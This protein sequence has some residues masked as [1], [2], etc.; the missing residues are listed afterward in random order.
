MFIG[1]QHEITILKDLFQKKTA[2]LVTVTGK[3]R[4]GKST[5][6]QYF[7]G[8][9]MDHF[10]EFQGIAPRD[11]IENKNQ[12]QHFSEQLALQFNL[13]TLELKNWNEAFSL[14]SNQV[15][16]KSCLILLD[17]ISW[18]ASKDRDFPGKLKVA[19]DTQ[20]KKNDKLILVICGSVST[21]I[22]K[23][24]FND[25][26][27]MGRLSKTIK[28]E[29][30]SLVDSHQFWPKERRHQISTSEKCK[31]LSVTGG[32]PRYLEE[33]DFSKSA[34]ENIKSLAFQK[35]GILFTEFEKIF[36][37]I[38]NTRASTYKKLVEIISYGHRS[39]KEICDALKIEQNGVISGYLMD[40]VNAGFVKK[41][42]RW[43]LN[44]KVSRLSRYRLS[45]NYLRFY[46]RY[47]L[48]NQDKIQKGLMNQL[49]LENLPGWASI[50]GLQFENLILNNLP[51]LC[52]LLELDANNLVSASPYFQKSTKRLAGV[53]ID[54]LIN[55]SNSSLYIFEMKFMKS[56]GINV[57]RE[58][59]E[60][61]KRLKVS[62]QYS[63]RPILIY[64]GKLTKELKE[65]EYFIHKLPF[66]NFIK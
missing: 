62:S 39:F 60:K 25:S 63:I 38:F 52:E 54:L 41:D 10:F 6:I 37:D 59:Q 46:L 24:I 49:S 50:M 58:I 34:E 44:G 66:S 7:S 57:K 29:E 32:V 11:G 35:E 53:Q 31:L 17:E 3:R 14:L 45:D 4:I 20:F 48:P 22:E 12:L 1:R 18:M 51:K 30:L 15:S 47:V 13:P 23:N 2:S 33:I 56:I 9:S 61:I 42:Y 43:N 27:F 65:D 16:G 55:M 26:D 19:W 64:E 28:L 21:W 8:M 40:L 5:L 36:N